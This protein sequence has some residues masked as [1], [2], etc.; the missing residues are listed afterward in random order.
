MKH[1]GLLNLRCLILIPIL[2]VLLLAAACGEDATST[3]LPTP[4]APPT[5]T[6]A[7]PTPTPTAVPTPTPSF[8]TSQVPR[9][10]VAMTPGGYE[11]NTT[12]RGPCCLGLVDKM[13]MY[14]TLISIDPTSGAYVPQLA[15]SWE[16]R[17]DGK[18]WTLDL[19]ENVPWH[20]GWGEFTADDVIHVWERVTSE[21]SIAT[22]LTLWRELVGR[23]GDFGVEG[24]HKI[25]FNLT[26]V[27]PDL[28]LHLA[29]RVGN[30]VMINKA[31]WDAEG[32]EGMERKPAGT[33]PYQFVE[34]KL[35]ESVLYER[36]ENHWRHTPDFKELLLRLAPENAT[37]LAMLLAGEAHIVDLPRD[38]QEDAISK[39]FTR[40]SSVIPGTAA[41][42]NF[43]GTY[44]SFPDDLDKTVP[45]LDKKVRE[46][47]NRA[48]NRDEIID[49]L[50][51]G[52]AQKAV[53]QY[54]HPS[55]QGWDPSWPD[56]FEEAYGYDPERARELL[57][58]AGYPDGFEFTLIANP[59]A[60][61]PELT[62]VSEALTIYFAEVGIDVVMEEVEYVKTRPDVRARK[63]HGKLIGWPPFGM[64]PPAYRTR[65][66]YDGRTEGYFYGFVHPDLDAKY[67]EV[68]A[69]LPRADRERIQRE[70]GEFL[71]FEYAGIPI[72][73]VAFEAIV[74]P[75]VVANYVINGA[76]SVSFTNLELVEAAK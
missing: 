35:A 16:M 38:I 7:P 52:R 19:E 70:M 42:Y 26:R 10:I 33:A 48:V 41:T 49:E 9:L 11:S 74:D 65:L 39:G 32:E 4:T 20:F 18:A 15:S 50:F 22:D 69:T 62:Q 45:W 5:A 59:W 73:H 1:H 3:P 40:V 76:Y 12:W 61:F 64:G 25:T 75:E 23:P 51:A 27:E 31:Q 28:D 66:L 6:T 36:I 2:V 56:R 8:F 53:A 37:R 55:E 46:A 21:D 14:E 24:Q 29:T 57:A 67:D 58:E 47:M 63:L 30:F 13:P 68:E 34:R 17:P 72:A 44:F 43:G 54:F 71:I 60:G